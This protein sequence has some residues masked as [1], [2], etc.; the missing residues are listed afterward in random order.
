MNN[1]LSSN[2][3]IIHNKLTLLAGTV[4]HTDRYIIL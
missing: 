3:G 1:E 4:I 2:Y